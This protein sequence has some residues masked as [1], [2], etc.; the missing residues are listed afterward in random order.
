M[1]AGKPHISSVAAGPWVGDETDDQEAQEVNVLRD[2]EKEMLAGRFWKAV[3][4]PIMS[5]FPITALTLD[6][7]R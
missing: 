4:Y 3:T 5:A 7:G 2:K 6:L 1:A